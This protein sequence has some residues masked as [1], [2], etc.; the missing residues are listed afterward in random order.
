MSNQLSL[1]RFVRASGPFQW[2][3]QPPT[4]SLKLKMHRVGL[5]SGGL[6]V[7]PVSCY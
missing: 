3:F 7:R 4:R 6:E 5:G 1:K 2:S